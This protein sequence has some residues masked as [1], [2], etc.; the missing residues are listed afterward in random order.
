MRR[1]RLLLVL[2]T[3]VLVFTLGNQTTTLAVGDDAT[4]TPGVFRIGLEANSAPFNWSQTT[5]ANGA[6]PIA[7]SPGEYVNGYDV[8]MAKRLAEG[9]GL[10]LEVQKI[11]WDGLVPA[12]QSGKIDAIVAGMSPTAERKLQIDFSGPYYTTDLVIMVTNDS[13]YLNATSLSD[14]SGA[15]VSGQLN[16]LNY[17]VIDQIDGVNKDTALPDYPTLISALTTDKIDGFVAEG[18]AALAAVASNPQLTFVRFEEGSGF[19]TSSEDTTVAVG[20]RKDSPLTPELNLI[21]DT[22]PEQERQD[23]MSQM[24]DFQ[25]AGEEEDLGFF[26]TMAQIAEEYAPLFLRGAAM[27]LIIAIISTI[28]GFIIG[29]FVQVIR[30]IPTDK[31]S[32]GPVRNFFLKVV[33]VILTIYVEVFRG[34][35]MMVQAVLIYYGSKLFFNVDMSPF[36]AAILIVSINTGAY[37][38]EVIRGGIDSVDGGQM[39]ACKAI[40]LTHGQ[41]MRHVILPQ[42]IKAILPS[43]ANEFVTNIKDTSVLN[44]ISVTELFFITRSVAGSTFQIFHTYLVTALIYFVLT[45]ATTRVINWLGKKNGQMKPFTLVSSSDHQIIQGGN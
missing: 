19:E 12:L 26:A 31:K 44:V 7:N 11:E 2:L 42:S 13:E 8:W 27:T 32:G 25:T 37:L 28:I 18:P 33:Q 15:T 20:V 23:A 22:I 3:L 45:F 41:S 30:T 24:I 17:N 4:E 39:E 10:E 5:D 36:L 29:L 14:F 40:G 6:V 34:T 35:P 9:L 16:T 21:L 43:V 1:N 38:T